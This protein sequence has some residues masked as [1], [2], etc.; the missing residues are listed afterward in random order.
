MDFYQAHGESEPPASTDFARSSTM[1][2]RA[3][4]CRQ[5][6]DCNLDLKAQWHVGRWRAPAFAEAV[7]LRAAFPTPALDPSATAA[8]AVN[9]E[10]PVL[11]ERSHY[12]DAGWLLGYP[13]AALTDTEHAL[14]DAHEI[15]QAATLMNALT[16]ASY[17]HIRCGNYA[18]ASALLNELVALADEK[19][20]LFW[21]AAGLLYQ[22]RVLAM[23]GKASDAIQ[24]LTSG[25]T[26]FR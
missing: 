12:F 13:E 14:K 16:F 2:T 20:A 4:H 23:M 21:K 18:T 3:E 7:R 1:T 26:A 11:P 9:Q 6:R 8:P 19:D 15:G 24:K 5:A 10:S 17:T 25:I 22:G